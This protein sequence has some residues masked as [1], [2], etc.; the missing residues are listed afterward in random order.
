MIS[1][2]LYSANNPAL[3]SLLIKSFLDGFEEVN[4]E[5]CEFPV[6]FLTLP[7]MLSSNIRDCFKGSNKNTGLLTWLSR[8]P[9]VLIDLS[10]RIE[11]TD[12]LTKNA[13]IFGANNHIFKFN[14]TGLLLADNSGILKKQFN[15]FLKEDKK[16]EVHEM[17]ICSKRFGIWCGHLES[18]RN[19]YNVMGL[20]I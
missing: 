11:A 15:L 20:S 16:S 14:E 13:L 9:Q 2:D 6:I 5:G 3:C 18:T 1:S 4:K 10:T 17:F 8:E 19:I 7:F 12:L